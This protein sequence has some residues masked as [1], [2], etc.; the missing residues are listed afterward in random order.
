MKELTKALELQLEEQDGEQYSRSIH[1][2][3]V[4]A[5]RKLLAIDRSRIPAYL[6]KDQKPLYR[7][8]ALDACG[9][10]PEMLRDGPVLEKVAE[11]LSDDDDDVRHAAIVVAEKV[12]DPTPR[13]MNQFVRAIRDLHGQEAARA[14]ELLGRSPLHPAT[15]VPILRTFLFDSTAR[16]AAIIALRA[17]GEAA[18]PAN[19]LLLVLTRTSDASIARKPAEAAALHGKPKRAQISGDLLHRKVEANRGFRRPAQGSSRAERDRPGREG[20]RPHSSSDTQ[21]Q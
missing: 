13:F 17:Y 20:C 1:L 4:Q 15:G 12:P 16:T 2:Q 10:N 6:V 14:A 3:R 8:A 9:D 5:L 18:A 11:A 21:G 19:E 7:A